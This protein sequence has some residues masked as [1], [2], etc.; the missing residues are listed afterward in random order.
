MQDTAT[1]SVDAAL[2]ALGARGRYQVLMVACG[3][4]GMFGAAFQL[5]S[6]MF[7]GGRRP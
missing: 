3:N 1:G 4:L 2:R 6:Y 5:L 7:T